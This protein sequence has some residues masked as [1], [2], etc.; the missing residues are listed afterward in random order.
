MK[1]QRL[2][3]APAKLQQKQWTLKIIL[4]MPVINPLVSMVCPLGQ[5]RRCDWV[6]YQTVCQRIPLPA[7]RHPAGVLSCRYDGWG[8]CQARLETRISRLREDLA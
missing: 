8:I 7:E 5:L 3:K 2:Q 4:M 1:L 6:D